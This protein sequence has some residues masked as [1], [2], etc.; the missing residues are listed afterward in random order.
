[1]PKE[2]ERLASFV[3]RIS[4]E[5]VSRDVIDAL[6]IRILDSI[7]CAIGA[8][9]APLIKNLR[10]QLDDFGGNPLASIIGGGKTAPD[11]A[12]FFNGALIRYLDFNDSFLAKYET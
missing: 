5:D 6:K 12:A 11:R 8:L 4:Y 2:V 1:M 3:H 10:T 9:R 7:G